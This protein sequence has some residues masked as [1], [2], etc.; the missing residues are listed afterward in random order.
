[1]EESV[2]AS[3]AVREPSGLH[4]T[5]GFEGPLKLVDG[6]GGDGRA[7]LDSPLGL[8]A[9]VVEDPHTL[10]EGLELRRVRLL[11][12]P[13]DIVFHRFQDFLLRECSTAG[14][15]GKETRFGLMRLAALTLQ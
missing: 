15:G 7:C 4:G 14:C 2:P 11:H 6:K 1:M 3:I 12:R 8:V 13:P 9:A 10:D 5:D